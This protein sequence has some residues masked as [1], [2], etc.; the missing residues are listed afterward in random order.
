MKYVR[1]EL[2]SVYERIWHWVQAVM[3]LML[4]WSG[5]CIHDPT[6]FG[7]CLFG[8]AVSVHNVLGFIVVGNAVFGLFYYLSTGTIQ[9]Y[10][11]R[12]HGFGV[13]AVR[14]AKYYLSGIFRGEPHPLEKTPEFRLNPLQQLTYLVIL[15]VL[16]PLQVITGV[17]MWS[18]Q[19]WPETVLAVG[20]VQWLSMVHDLVA[21]LFAA[22]VLAHVYLTTTGHTP[23]ANIKAM[24]LGY[25]EVPESH[26]AYAEYQERNAESTVSS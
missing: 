15:N 23:L 8:S 2:Y 13:L 26:A 7:S 3:I 5:L 22:F 21:W 18:G 12:P 17:L 20:G 1:M 16:L 4:I 10:L 24:V 11:P 25:E 9:Q 14:Q 19:K 6:H